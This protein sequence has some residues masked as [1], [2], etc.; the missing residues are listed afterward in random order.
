MCAVFGINSFGNDCPTIIS[1]APIKF[2]WAFW[3][4]ARNRRNKIRYWLNWFKI[5]SLRISSAR[6]KTALSLISSR[7]ASATISLSGKLTGSTLILF[8]NDREQ[9]NYYFQLLTPINL[10]LNN[11]F[12]IVTCFTTWNTSKVS[13][14][15]PH[16][17]FYR[18]IWSQ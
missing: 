2:F 18:L 9:M 8:W 11:S 17:T 7:S 6:T 3:L 14:L 12:Y 16:P 10:I 5:F 1:N 13:R 4:L 15:T